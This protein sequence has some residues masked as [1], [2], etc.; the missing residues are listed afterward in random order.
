MYLRHI[1]MEQDRRLAGG[2]RTLPLEWSPR[3]A[4]IVGLIAT[5]GCLSKDR[6]HISFDTNDRQLVETF[7]SCLGRPLRYRTMKTVVGNDRYQ[8][9]F[10][11]VRFYRW[12]VDAGLTPRKSLTLGA[13]AAPRDFFAPLV[14]GLL[15]G[16]GNIYTLLHAPTRKKYP[17]YTY[18]RL[19]THFTSASEGHIEWL[20]SEISIV[21]GLRGYIERRPETDERHAFFRLKFGNR[22]SVT[23]LSALYAAPGE[24]RL[25]RKWQ[26]FDGYL[27]RHARADSSAEGGT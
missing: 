3:M 14:R 24:P 10:S 12:L 23:L 22:A 9:Q 15:D 16:D 1:P 2:F 20:R 17:N 7:L 25:E 19:W 13:I 5:D 21:M 11:D 26:K 4:Y 18:E 8:A 27:R 6:R